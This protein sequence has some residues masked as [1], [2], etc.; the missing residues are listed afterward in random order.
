MLDGNFHWGPSKRKHNS[1]TQGKI[2]RNPPGK[3]NQRK[4]FFFGGSGASNI[5]R[6]AS[7]PAAGPTVDQIACTVSSAP[8]V[9]EQVPLAWCSRSILYNLS[10]V[11]GWGGWGEACGGQGMGCEVG[12]GGGWAGVGGVGGGVGPKMSSSHRVPKASRLKTAI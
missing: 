8:K 4:L 2:Q 5:F 3:G 10:S 11:G 12:L 9:W 6:T 1:E 7:L